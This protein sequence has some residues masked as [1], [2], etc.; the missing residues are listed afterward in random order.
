MLRTF[1]TEWCFIEKVSYCKS[2]CLLKGEKLHT[3][4]NRHQMICSC[5]APVFRCLVFCCNQNYKTFKNDSSENYIFVSFW[6]SFCWLQSQNSL[7]S[8]YLVIF[9][10]ISLPKLERNI[11]TKVLKKRQY[12]LW[13]SLHAKPLWELNLSRHAW[14]WKVCLCWNKNELTWNSISA[15][16]QPLRNLKV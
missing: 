7:G 13:W 9:K 5:E 10:A 8:H 11:H 16:F 2:I 14:S 12:L 6:S 15:P 3:F 4:L 1:A